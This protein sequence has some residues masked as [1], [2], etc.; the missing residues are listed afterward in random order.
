MFPIHFF[1]HLEFASWIS[2]AESDFE[3][4]GI[5]MGNRA[6]MHERDKDVAGSP[7]TPNLAGDQIDRATVGMSILNSPV[8]SLFS[9]LTFET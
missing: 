8:A 6:E 9:T 2:L 4:D 5:K 3:V 1:V 7:E